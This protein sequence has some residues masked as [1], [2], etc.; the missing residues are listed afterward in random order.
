MKK[1]L[2]P[3]QSLPRSLIFAIQNI[4]EPSGV[5][6]TDSPLREAESSEYGACRLGLNYHNAVLR[7]AKTTPTKIGQFVTI[8]KRQTADSEI[9]PLD[10]S[11]ENSL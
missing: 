5:K 11:Y 4:Y 2:P 8:W 6:V 9:A 1:E 10:I 3:L 7:E